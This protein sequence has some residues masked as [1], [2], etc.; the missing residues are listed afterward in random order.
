MV[1]RSHF[2]RQRLFSV[3]LYIGIALLN[4]SAWSAKPEPETEWKPPKLPEAVTIKPE[5]AVLKVA[6]IDRETRPEIEQAAAQ[7][8]SILQAYWNENKTKSGKKTTDHEF[9]RRAYLELAGRIPTIDEARTFCDATG[10]KKRGQLIDDLLESPGYVSHFYNYWAD[11]LRLKERPSRD[12]FFEPYM[13]WVKESIAENMPYDKWVNSLLTA[14]GRVVE[15]PATGFQ[16]RDTGMP[17]AYVDNTVR[18]FLGTQ[19]GCA[20]CHDHPFDRW[21]QQEFYKL[22]ALTNGSKFSAKQVLFGGMSGASFG[23]DDSFS[24]SGPASDSPFKD[25]DDLIPNLARLR[26]G[27]QTAIDEKKVG[28]GIRN[29]YA[30]QTKMISS[31]DDEFRLPHDYQYDD[32]EPLDVVEPAVLWGKIPEYAED[33]DNRTRFAAWL[34]SADNRQFARNIANRM[35]KKIMGV[36]LV[37][38]IDD[39]QEGNIPAIPELL[40]HLTD[41]MLR[42]NFDLREFVRLLVSTETYQNVAVIYDPTAAEPHR[43]AGPAL[44]RMTAEQL[45]DSLLTLIAANEWAYQR[46]TAQDLQAVYGID[47]SVMDYEEFEQSYKDYN[48]YMRGLNRT[49][50]K[51]CGYEGL[52]LVRAS[53]LPQPSGASHLLR[54][55][56]Q[57]DRETIETARQSA[58]V[59]QILTLFNGWMTHAMLAK[60]SVIYDSVS[61]QNTMKSAVDTIF[62]AILTHE[63]DADMRRAAEQEIKQ[64]SNPAAG[65]G[66]L[67]WALLNT[68]EFLFID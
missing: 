14:N 19:I 61:Q 59:P 37:E 10:R 51:N 41:E 58:T 5:G 16:L 21:T 25:E 7:I 46:P 54:Q 60:G 42:L 34:T 30:A 26:Y 3:S 1:G 66:N 17:L 38:P 44:K 15:N 29:F 67:I 35:W 27:M 12:I 33:E 52:T 32:G 6:P 53:E 45:W 28:G 57:G 8:D 4:G 64:A 13:A 31:M 56:G 68:R 65:C 49:R 40:E 9:V 23:T 55:F 47:M 11:I 18:V 39:F 20:Q 36:G 22:A 50:N 24:D 62:L 43:Y 48:E 63:P 2:S